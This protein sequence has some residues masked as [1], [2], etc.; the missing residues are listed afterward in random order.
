MGIAV[1]P[2]LD[3]LM[4]CKAGCIVAQAFGLCPMCVC[5]CLQMH[6][7]EWYKTTSEQLGG[8]ALVGQP[9]CVDWGKHNSQTEEDRC[10]PTQ[11]HVCDRLHTACSRVSGLGQM[12]HPT[13]RQPK[14]HDIKT[15]SQQSAISGRQLLGV[16]C[17]CLT[18]TC[19][20]VAR[21]QIPHH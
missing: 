13:P 6:L 2:R 7:A 15:Q 20:L 8:R 3:A 10:V 11:V 12:P 16:Q 4:D 18:T 19:L 21:S 1:E 5:V 17:N 14:T 9:V